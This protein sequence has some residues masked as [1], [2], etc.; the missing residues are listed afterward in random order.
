MADTLASLVIKVSSTDVELTRKRL[1]DLGI[2]AQDTSARVT[3]SADSMSRSSDNLSA[4]LKGAAAAFLSIQSARGLTQIA[5]QMT[6]LE[7]RIKLTL[8]ATESYAQIQGELLKVANQN[9]VAL[10]DIGT[11]YARIA[12]SVQKLGG[13]QREAIGITNAL[14]KALLISGA[15]TAEASSAIIQFSQAMASGVLRGEE[16]NAISEAA[17]VLLDKLSKQLGVTRGE[18]RAMAADG[19]LTA[20]VVGNAM[21]N[22]V[23][24][25]TI[26]A[27]K[28]APTVGGAFVVLKNEAFL[29]VEQFNKLGSSTDTLSGKLAGAVGNV[30]DFVRA[31]R[32]GNF[33][34]TQQ[35]VIGIAGGVA[36]IATAYAAVRTALTLATGAQIAFNIAAR[37]NPY[38]LAGTALVGAVT[39]VVGY[40][41]A[42]ESAKNATQKLADAE[43][44]RAD[45]LQRINSGTMSLV[46]PSRRQMAGVDARIASLKKQV[47][48][49]KN[50][51]ELK[52]INEA[53]AEFAADQAA[54][55]TQRTAA[56]YLKL[57]EAGA[58]GAGKATKAMNEAKRAAEAAAKAIQDTLDKQAGDISRSVLGDAGAARA[59]FGAS[60]ASASQQAQFAM[61]QEMAATLAAVDQAWADIDEAQKKAAESAAEYIDKFLST[62]FGSNLAAG[63]DKAG[64]SLGAF[65]GGF[66]KLIQSQEMYNEARLKAGGDSVKLAKIEAKNQQN[67]IGAYADITGAAKGFFKEGSK[68]YKSLQAAEQVFR[69]FQLAMSIKT[70]AAALLGDQQKVASAISSVGPQVA[71]SQAIGTA[72]AA[73]AVATQGGGDPYT[74]FPRIA[75]M[76]A[77]MAAIGFAVGGG[78][79]EGPGFTDNTGTGTVFGDAGAQSQ[80]VN[81]SID[82]LSEAATLENRISSA[83]LASLRNI[84]ANIG[85]LTNLVVRNAPGADLA[86]S[87]KTGFEMNSFG[88]GL[89]TAVGIVTLGASELLGIGKLLGGLFGKKV[90]I[91]GQGLTAVPQALEDIL[92]N[93]FDLLSFVAIQ[94]KK[95]SF[96]IT[97]STKNSIKT[98]IADPTLANQFSLIFSNFADAIVSA[99]EPLGVSTDTVTEKLNSF[100]VDIGKINLKGL[101]GEEIQEKL[102][103][104]FG[105]QADLM[106][107][108]ALP[109]LGAFQ[110]VGE[111]YFE[112]L[113]RVASGIEQATTLL[114]RL[115]LAAIDYRDILATQGNVTTEIIRQSVLLQDATAGIA[116]G[117]AEIVANFDGTG[118]EITD[119][120]IQLRE[121]QNSLTAAGKAGQFLTTFMIAGA[122]GV[123]RLTDGLSTYFDDFLSPA[124]QAAELTR[125]LTEQ[126]NRVGVLLPTTTDAFKALVAGIDISTEAGQRMF[127][128]VIALA[129]AF[130]ELQ[131]SMETAAESTN[132]LVSSLRDLA[133]EA[134]RQSAASAPVQNLSALR[135][136][137]QAASNRA[138]LGDS[139]AAA[140]LPEIG[141]LLLQASRDYSASSTAYLSDLALIT[142]G[143]T[144]AADVQERGMGFTPESGYTGPAIGGTVSYPTTTPAST[145]VAAMRQEM[146]A[147]MYQ[148]AKYTQQTAD[149]LE[150]WSDGDRMNVRIDNETT[151]PALVRTVA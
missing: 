91:K 133:D 126:F 18:L 26:Q 129:P 89:R 52:I 150:R 71:A 44:Q 88:K 33:T 24:E 31:V 124:E 60:G 47:A 59:E 141:K 130:S 123:D 8:K 84:E 122:G 132:N 96:G 119:L 30:T 35:T 139:T 127:G 144:R 111:G 95:K 116:G 64:Q 15:S 87:V 67:Q 78:G 48:A 93:G 46:E 92:A 135:A 6:N 23:E 142:A 81:K 97:T 32:E 40:T 51:A 131:D 38:V 28:M 42:T 77:L 94:T 136:Q 85:G 112:T 20:G 105:Q 120:V 21:L 66:D 114:D 12:P 103:A 113:V 137:F 86:E 41:K 49:E 39:A 62:D 143:A 151:D 37:A 9:R 149:L 45:L 100:V 2:T 65:V 82:L 145:E 110:Q 106:A 70:T 13:T 61:N 80:S 17:P 68:G 73:E 128:Q 140:A 148:L 56:G 115:G 104:V 14:S 98:S 7:S 50:A 63:F 55:A 69:A 138:G 34:E 102:T 27:A 134:R 146:N 125:R 29:V 58:V 76:I 83:M 10:Q 118:E 117:F 25:L 5:D 75:A 147:N 121:L 4:S 57:G 108:A 36:A 74:A 90:S 43:K 22:S 107:Q 3:R 99:A 101:S 54:K 11:L 16:F 53:Q 79:S 19:Q 109:M 72:K 1:R